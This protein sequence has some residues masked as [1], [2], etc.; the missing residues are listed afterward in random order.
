[1]K[2][3]LS[4]LLLSCMLLSCSKDAFKP[5]STRVVGTWHISDINRTGFGGNISDLPFQSGT[6]TFNNNG[7]MTYVDAQGGQYNGSWDI[8]ERYYDD[9]YHKTLDI[10]VV[11]FTTQQILREYYEEMDFR[12]TDH[13]V[14]KVV[15]GWH[16]YTTHFRR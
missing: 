15:D 16:S 7:S 12:S 14:V 9:G 1:M 11:N 13:F 8:S 2:K 10:V 5:Y 4:F 6:F 3:I